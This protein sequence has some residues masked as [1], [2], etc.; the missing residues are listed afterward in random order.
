[1]VSKIDTIMQGVRERVA[2]N[3]RERNFDYQL[4]FITYGRNGVMGSLEPHPEEV[5]HELG[6]VIE[7]IAPTQ[8]QADT[9]CAFARSTM[10]HFGY[11]GRRA[12]AGNLAFPY[13]P[14]DFHAGAVYVFSMYHLIEL[15]DPL[16]PFPITYVSV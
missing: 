6:I 3:F 11:E 9:I 5:A 16:Q 2:D 12:T 15:T 8:A 7:A 4:H 1:M 13:S 14:S 10:L